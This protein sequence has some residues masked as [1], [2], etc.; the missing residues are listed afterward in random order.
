MVSNLIDELTHSIQSKELKKYIS[1][2]RDTLPWLVFGN[3]PRPDLMNRLNG[4]SIEDLFN[5]VK[6]YDT[7]LAL[8]VKSGLYIWNDCMDESHA[9]AQNI[10]AAEGSYFH[11]IIHRREP[12]YWNSGYWF[13]KTGDHPVFGL[14]HDFVSD[15]AEIELPTP[16]NSLPKWDWQIFNNLCEQAVKSGN[17]ND[18][19]LTSIQL[20]EIVFLIT[21]SYRHAIAR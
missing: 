14:I 8:A 3:T 2:L 21:H 16:L 20:T 9:I 18:S 6:I 7:D 11:A 12:D 15:S 19:I 13:R 17:P 4:S 10:K 1:E 5:P